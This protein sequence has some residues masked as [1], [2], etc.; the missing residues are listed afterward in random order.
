MLL[1]NL[2]PASGRQDHTA[3]PSAFGAYV[4]RAIRVHRI[5]PRVRDVRTPLCGVDGGSSKIDLPDVLSGI[6]FA[7]GLDG[8]KPERRGDLPVGYMSSLRQVR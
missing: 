5:Q 6:F 3:L 2:T 1:K 4:S 7:Q 8:G